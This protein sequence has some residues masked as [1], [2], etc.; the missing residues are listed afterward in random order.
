MSKK[1]LINA[2]L[3]EE[4]RVAIVDDGILCEL[5]I[6]VA[7]HE[8][9]KGNIYKAVVVRVEPGLQAAFIDYGAE[10]LGFLQIDE[11]N[12]R[13]VKPD[14]AKTE[15]NR[16]RPKI[17]DLLSRGQEL[18]VQ[19][20]REER[21]T[22]GAA[23][24]TYLSLAGRYMVLMPDNSTRGVSRR[25]ENDT[26]RKQLKQVMTALELPETFGYIVRTAALDQTKEE[27]ERDYRYL[28]RLYENIYEIQNKAKAPALIY[29][30]SN[31]VIRSI[32]DYF[33]AEMDEVLID[34]PDMFREAKEFFSVVMP[35][36]VGLVKL[37]QERRPIFS[38]FQIEDQIETIN[39]NKVALPSGGS[40]VIDST[41]AL[42]AI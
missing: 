14:L 22:K 38:R 41:E 32:R 27:L 29:R 33:S 8:Q 20:I 9:T 1:M 11:I 7:G 36:S 25:A 24:T 39:S 15:K 37:H 26:Q 13:K 30:E 2:T 17:S 16:G 5:D 3:D 21:G 35:D 10:R 23:L 31:L 40:I 6:E 34:D 42:V 28:M 18:L 12:F 19:I 4:N